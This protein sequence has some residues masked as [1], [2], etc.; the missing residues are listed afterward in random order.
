MT[1][2]TLEQET[3][4]LVCTMS[5]VTAQE[6]AHRGQLYR[7]DSALV[8]AA[9]KYFAPVGT[10][11][12]EWPTAHDEAV[13]SSAAK[14]QAE[15]DAR[16]QGRVDRANRHPVRIETSVVR[17]LRDVLDLSQGRR[18]LKGSTLLA[19]DEVVAEHPDDFKPA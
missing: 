10:P 5:F 14:A 7:A 12:S 15:E 1:T 16:H 3:G 17:A 19:T 2:T 4:I 9:P 11:Q 18:I 8:A 13:A 6:V